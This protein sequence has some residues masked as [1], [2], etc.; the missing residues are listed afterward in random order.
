M[1]HMMLFL[2]SVLSATAQTAQ[3]HPPSPSYIEYLEGRRE[4]KDVHDLLE[5]VKMAHEAHTSPT[6]TEGFS[7][8]LEKEEAESPEED[9]D[10]KVP[11]DAPSWTYAG[12]DRAEA[13]CRPLKAGKN[14]KAVGPFT[15][16]QFYRW[17]KQFND[18]VPDKVPPTAMDGIETY[19]VTVR[20]YLLA[21]RFERGED[22]DLHYQVSASPKWESAQCIFEIPAVKDYQEARKTLWALV[23]KD[24]S[25]SH[26]RG[27]PDSWIMEKP[28][29]I[30]T[31]GFL[32]LDAHHRPHGATDLDVQNGGRGIMKADKKNHVRGLYELHPVIE[33][34]P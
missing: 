33:V 23:M 17:V 16:D 29:E 9:R 20:A 15:L 2:I 8:R 4:G 22:H 6:Y 26:P 31:T 27:T 12:S 1:R 3:V 28:V 25:T 18:R 34:R 5:R 13:K 24:A 7:I 30:T 19:K 21:A 14:Y 32:L 11:A 10:L